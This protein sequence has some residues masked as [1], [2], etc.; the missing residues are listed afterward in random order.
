MDTLFLA[1]LVLAP[2]FLGEYGGVKVKVKVK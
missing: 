2:T 1:P